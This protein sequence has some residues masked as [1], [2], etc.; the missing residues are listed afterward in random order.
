MIY[1]TMG[2]FTL[3]KG[4]ALKCL[5]NF[6]IIGIGT[7]I[8]NINSLP[9]KKIE[10]KSL[11]FSMKNIQFNNLGDG[12]NSR[13]FII[14]TPA[15]SA[16]ETIYYNVNIKDCSF[17]NALDRADV[18]L[19]IIAD[20]INDIGN[21][22]INNNN[23]VNSFNPLVLSS[24]SSTTAVV[25]NNIFNNKSNLCGDVYYPLNSYIALDGSFGRLKIN[26]NDLYNVGISQANGVL[27]NLSINFN[28]FILNYDCT[29]NL[30]QNIVDIGLGTA[31]NYSQCFFNGNSIKATQINS[32]FTLTLNFIKSYRNIIYS[33]VYNNSFYKTTYTNFGQ[34][35]DAGA[36]LTT[37]TIITNNTNN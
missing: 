14:L 27:N 15:R 20:N 2:E 29:K 21:I 28:N 19:D 10:I 3:T 6:S 32:S 31:L 16:S 4:L 13:T 7:P 24:S 37:G 9:G 36:N 22:T 1:D 33:Q 34:W 8:I 12:G 5:A 30:T 11:S 26:N 35:L 17:I 25:E 18:F 23:F